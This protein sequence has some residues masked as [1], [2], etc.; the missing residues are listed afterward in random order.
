MATVKKALSLVPKI[1]G[2]LGV[3]IKD[4]KI[5]GFAS[6]FNEL[7]FFQF[8]L[9]GMYALESEEESIRKTGAKRP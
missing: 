7:T 4:G 6:G 2:H 9:D 3:E 5:V 8:I 1:K